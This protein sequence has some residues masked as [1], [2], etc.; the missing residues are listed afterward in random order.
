MRD[1]EREAETPPA[2]GKAAS[3]MKDWMD[4]ESQ[5]TEPKEDV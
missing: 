5:L 4:L 3:L 1:T 2:E